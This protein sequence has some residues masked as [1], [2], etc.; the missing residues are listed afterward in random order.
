MNHT[1]INLV[2]AINRL[3]VKYAYVMLYSFYAI[4][5]NLYRSIFCIMSLPP[6]MNPPCRH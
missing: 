6:R 4:T 1:P 2:I 5:R 3:Y